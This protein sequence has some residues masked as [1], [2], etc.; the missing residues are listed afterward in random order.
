MDETIY[1]FFYES[2]ITNASVQSQL[3]FLL[4]GKIIVVTFLAV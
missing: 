2:L 3:I 4:K 1:D